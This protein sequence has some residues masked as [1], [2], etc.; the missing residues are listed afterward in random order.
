MVRCQFYRCRT[1]PNLTAFGQHPLNTVHGVAEG[2]RP[3]PIQPKHFI[4]ICLALQKGTKEL[5]KQERDIKATVVQWFQQQPRELFA[6]GI[7]QL[8]CQRDACITA[9]GPYF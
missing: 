2:V 8:V 1:H 6:K 3:P 5:Q 4:S 9:C 7:H